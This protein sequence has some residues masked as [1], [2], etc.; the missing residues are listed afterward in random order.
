LQP[1]SIGARTYLAG[2]SL[3]L[4]LAIFAPDTARAQSL[5]EALISA[6]AGN[7][8]LDAE[9]ARQRADQETIKQE[10]AKGLP[11]LSLDAHRGEEKTRINS[12][13]RSTKLLQDGYALTLTQPLF[14]GFQT[15]NGTR[16]AKAEVRAGAAQLH[17]R[18]QS[19]LLDTVTAYMDVVQDRKI[20]KLRKSNIRF[21][22]NELAATKARHRAG[23]LSKTDVAQARTRLYEG[24]ADLAQAQANA[25]ASEASFEAI[26]GSR[27]GALKAPRVPVELLPPSLNDALGVARSTNPTIIS[28]LHSQEAARRAKNEAYG[29]LLP[30]VSLEMSHGIDNNTSIVVDK[31]EES[32]LFVRMKM[33]LYQGG[34]TRSRIRQSRASE[35][36]AAYEVTD[37]RRRTRASVIDTWKQ[38]HAAKARIKAARQ[39]VKAARAALKGVQIEVKVGERA[40]FEVLD[41]Q[42]E[43]VN[44]EVAL[45]RAQHDHVVSSYALLAATGRLT[46]RYLT[47]PVAYPDL[48]NAVSKKNPRVIFKEPGRGQRRSS[49]HRQAPPRQVVRAVTPARKPVAQPMNLAPGQWQTKVSETAPAKPVQQAQPAQQAKPMRTIRLSSVKP[50]RR[51][52]RRRAVQRQ[53]APVN[54]LSVLRSSLPAD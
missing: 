21:L 34:D 41:A 19:I 22:R 23:D 6:F 12:S 33:P 7:P 47:L 45:A 4:A 29:A 54:P 52:S 35:T 17:D 20:A 3:V 39:Q 48:D 18:E 16:R 32:S 11:N 1:Q 31:E 42:R 28:A 44:G 38:L 10:R 37:S 5:N 26:I 30:T 49:I 25:E 36:G 15:Y 51:R 53:A 8:G 43:L 2:C 27:P 46:A 50:T 24:E 40:L 14:Q 13:S 9:R